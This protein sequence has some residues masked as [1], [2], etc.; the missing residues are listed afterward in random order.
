MPGR[1]RERTGNLLEANRQP[2]TL[3]EVDESIFGGL[4]AQEAQVQRARFVNG[5]MEIGAFILSSVG[6]QTRSTPTQEE[7]QALGNILGRLDAS[8]QWLI[9]DWFVMGERVW[10]QTYEQVADIVGR[11]VQT[12]YNYAWVASCVD[13]SVR[14]ENLS[15]EHHKLVARLPPER[16]RELLSQAVKEGWST[17]KLREIITPPAL[18]DK[19]DPFE[20]DF[21]RWLK[22]AQAVGEGDRRAIAARLRAL[23]D[24]IE[25]MG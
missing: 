12:L 21:D 14:T 24:A 17:R 3:Q 9:G 22:R 15:F 4:V 2:Q 11:D 8:I 10:G 20:R 18:S 25:R 23:A 16:Q 1:K 19:T 6:L 7:W 5:Q 13:F